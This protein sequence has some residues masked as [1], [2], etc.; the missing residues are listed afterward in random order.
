MT[1]TFLYIDVA[2]VPMTA[3]FLYI[4]IAFVPLTASVL[5]HRNRGYIDIEE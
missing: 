4:D 3:S 1:A 5:C 2:S